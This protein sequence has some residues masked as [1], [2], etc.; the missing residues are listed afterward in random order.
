M[1]DKGKSHVSI[2]V[3]FTHDTVKNISSMSIQPSTYDDLLMRLRI[4][5]LG[6]DPWADHLRKSHIEVQQ[7]FEIWPS[8]LVKT[9]GGSGLDIAIV[10]TIPKTM[11]SISN[12]NGYGSDVLESWDIAGPGMF[13]DFL[14]P[15]CP[16]LCNNQDDSDFYIS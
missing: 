6:L 8:S 16:T 14:N 1:T 12:E 9:Y 7:E 3:R 2:D 5:S 13:F 11:P 4:K 10:K 15:T